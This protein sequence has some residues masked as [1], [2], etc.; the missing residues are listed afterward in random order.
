MNECYLNKRDEKYKYH[1][2]AEAQYFVGTK[3]RN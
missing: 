2:E 3:R 1:P